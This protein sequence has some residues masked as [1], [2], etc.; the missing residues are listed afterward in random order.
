[1]AEV[2][3]RQIKGL[4]PEQRLVL[5]QLRDRLQ[6]L[7]P[8]AEEGIAWGMPAFKNAGVTFICFQGF[9]KH[10]SIFPMSALVAGR[11]KQE[12][13]AYSTSKGTIQF[14]RDKSFPKPLLRKII[15][16]RMEEINDSYPRKSG[17]YLHFY[18]NGFLQSKGRYKGEVMHGKWEWYRK[19]GSLMRSGEFKAGEQ[20]G[21]W[22]T[23]DRTGKAAK[24]TRF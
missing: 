12:L 9:S 14:E 21:T 10:N 20:V 22:V 16:T 4:P 5:L 23:Y 8:G 18:S 1:M 3:E 2:I 13:S 6:E 17:E 19:D 15:E 7:L 11:L 24:T